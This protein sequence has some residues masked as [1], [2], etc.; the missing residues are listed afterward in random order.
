MT[1]N[2]RLSWQLQIKFKSLLN[3]PTYRKITQEIIL[4]NGCI[5]AEND[6]SMCIKM[7]FDHVDEMMG[8]ISSISYDVSKLTLLNDTSLA[9]LQLP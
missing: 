9:S 1:M 2:L 4:S 7:P 6:Y 3:Q 5:Y 8:N